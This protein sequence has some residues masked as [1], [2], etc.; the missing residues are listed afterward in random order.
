MRFQKFVSF[1]IPSLSANLVAGEEE[2]AHDKQVNKNRW[3]T[4][5]ILNCCIAYRSHGSL[6]TP[7]IPPVT[8]FQENLPRHEPGDLHIY[9]G[10]NLLVTVGTCVCFWLYRVLKREATNP[11]PSSSP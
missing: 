11:E 5:E 1:K 2:G 4:M 6:N 10:I 3:K 9:I 7:L 8:K